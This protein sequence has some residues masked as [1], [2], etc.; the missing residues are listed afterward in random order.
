M[1]PDWQ[2]LFMGE[3]LTIKTAQE[4]SESV[5][6]LIRLEPCKS[7]PYVLIS[8]FGFEN[9]RRDAGTHNGRPL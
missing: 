4:I 1:D 5:L 6:F 3:Q 8:A 7:K 2:L 9:V